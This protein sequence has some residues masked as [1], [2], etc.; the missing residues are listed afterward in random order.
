MS[1]GSTP[2]AKHQAKIAKHGHS[3]KLSFTEQALPGLALVLPCGTRQ[4]PKCREGR[5]CS[6]GDASRERPVRR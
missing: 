5:A 6:R 1:F 3:A 4:P 2:D